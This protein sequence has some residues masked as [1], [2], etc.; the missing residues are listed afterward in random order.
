[1]FSGKSE[2]LIRRLNRSSIGRKS[3]VAIKPAVDDRYD[4]EWITAH[5]GL[6][7]PCM[8]ER[9][10]YSGPNLIQEVVGIDEVQFFGNGIVDEIQKAVEQ[11]KR[12]IV[13]GLDRTYRGE[14]FGAMPTLLALADDVLKLTA[15]CHKCGADATLTQRLIDGNPAPFSGDTIQVGGLDS[16][17]ARCRQCFERA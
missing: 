15:V 12:V 9:A 17:E 16:Y 1:M 8:H 13:A 7:Y 6:K 14:P 5:S 10:F 3:V 2:E 4:T 11:D